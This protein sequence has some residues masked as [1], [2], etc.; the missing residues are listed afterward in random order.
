MH[1]LAQS[2]VVEA[3]EGSWVY[4]SGPLQVSDPRNTV[5]VC[6][7]LAEAAEGSGWQAYR[8]YRDLPKVPES[9]VPLIEQLRYAVDHADVCLL[10]V[11]MPSSGVG[12]ELAFACAGKRPVIAVSLQGEQ[13][14]LVVSSL[15]TNYPRARSVVGTD[16]QECGNQVKLLL[17]DPEFVDIVR[18]AAGEDHAHV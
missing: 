9:S 7:K 16:A 4:V 6:E 10:Y 2:P 14:S 5:D 1:E 12:A 11:G 18:Q 15:L 3:D 8:S 13:P 17:A